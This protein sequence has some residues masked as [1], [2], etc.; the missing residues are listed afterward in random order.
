MDGWDLALLAVVGYVAVAAMVR[1]MLA[2]RDRSLA[3]LREQ[4]AREKRRRKKA[5][6]PAS[7]D[8]AA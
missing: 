1:L 5:K 2:R 7:R 3:D 8:K 6:K 4:L